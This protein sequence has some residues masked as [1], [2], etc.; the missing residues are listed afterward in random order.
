MF[1][2]TSK[3]F[4]VIALAGITCAG[5]F[6]EAGAKSSAVHLK[7]VMKAKEHC[8]VSGTNSPAA[9]TPS[10]E[11]VISS[12]VNEK[13]TVKKEIDQLDEEITQLLGKITKYQNLKSDN[14]KISRLYLQQLKTEQK[15][16]AEKER[17]LS[18]ALK[19]K[20]ELEQD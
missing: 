12:D 4:F 15:N 19:L 11:E 6:V 13:T 16:L 2:K 18:G 7:P 17:E 5:F 8:V 20:E 10:S 3:H 1:G 9:E 14:K